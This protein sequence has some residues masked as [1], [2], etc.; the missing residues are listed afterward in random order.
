[1][2]PMLTGNALLFV[3]LACTKQ[4][5][6]DTGPRVLIDVQAWQILDDDQDPIGAAPAPCGAAG[7][8]IES[9]VLEVRTD[10][11]PWVTLGQPSL[12][13]LSAEESLSL[14]AWHGTLAAPE[15]AAGHMS[16]WIGAQEIWRIEPDI[17]SE[18]VIYDEI[19]TVPVSAPE[20]TLIRLH[21]HNHGANAWRLGKLLP[22]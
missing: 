9:S 2:G 16:L 1:M 11:C 7:I 17:P 5:P 14:L 6:E 4:T 15:P 13:D 3:L 20:A 18:G 12:T 19:L 8:Q 21:F 22:E 10:T